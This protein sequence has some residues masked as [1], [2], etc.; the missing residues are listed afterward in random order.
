M[1]VKELEYP[2]QYGFYT[3]F[4][5]LYSEGQAEECM[6]R[7]G[8][9]LNKYDLKEQSGNSSKHD[10][11][12]HRDHVLITYGDKV[13]ADIQESETHLRKLHNFL[14]KHLSELISTIHLLPFFP[15]SS[16]DGFS[17]MDYRQVDEQIGT[18]EDIEDMGKD[19]RLMAD[20]VIN[21]S[22]RQSRWFDKF[23]NGEYPYNNYFIEVDSEAD[24]SEVIRPRS[25]PVRTPVQTRNGEK[26]VWTTFSNDQIDVDFSNTDVLFEFL[27]IFLFY[28]SKGIRVIRLDA[29][30]YLWKKAGTSCIHLPETHEVVKLFR[31][32]VN[33]Y[34]PDV[35]LITET[36]VPHRENISYFGKG[37]EAHMVY[38]FS[39][40]PLLLHALLTENASYL[41][42]W[43]ESLDSL[44]DGCTY[45]NFTSSHDGIGVRPLEGLVPDH[46]LE[47]LV[48]GMRERGGFV[49]YK[50]NADATKSPYELNITY[51][52][53]FKSKNGQTDIQ[54]KKYLC[55]QIIML[56]LVG[57]P[58]IYFH[59]LTATPNYR[60]G[61]EV[62]GRYRTI[63][64]K[65]WT[66]QELMELLE[67]PDSITYRVFN[68]YCNLIRERMRHPAF[69][70]M[71]K[72]K[73]YDLGEE[74]FCIQ[75]TDPDEKE[76]IL[77][78]CNIT[79]RSRQLNT[80]PA[81]LPIDPGQS[82][83]DEITGEK[84]IE[85]GTVM[86]HP[87]DAIWIKL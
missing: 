7:L 72:Q 18:W 61:V 66:Y 26:M 55:S 16:D 45:F 21:H 30:A 14:K 5:K 37:D 42:E 33:T 78:L 24:L 53:A 65:K 63:N 50:D 75:R 81:D 10:L 41:T 38:Q 12:T 6:E 22:S 47:W 25:A 39:L 20:L 82:Y 48:E 79:S 59:N 60:E 43:A 31:T 27:D 77:V 86:L 46:E 70:P 74:Y 67:D 1:K 56:S 85:N 8:A 69:H 4:R 52:D 62:T 58:G 68:R 73:V 44:P 13:R 40:P 9:L 35:T 83:Q 51:F 87:F 36:N 28:L 29:V 15:S 3:H 80:E 19:F 64:R 17:V 57:V 2:V 32:L 23:V 49:T 11:W 34:M 54:E 84:R 71:G 76:S